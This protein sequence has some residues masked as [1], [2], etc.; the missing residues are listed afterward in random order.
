MAMIETVEVIADI[1]NWK[2]SNGKARFEVCSEG[3]MIPVTRIE[4]TR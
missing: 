3:A 4:M 2:C 1:Q